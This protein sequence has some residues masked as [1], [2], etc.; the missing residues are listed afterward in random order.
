M[1]TTRSGG[2]DAGLASLPTTPPA[3]DRAMRVAIADESPLLIDGV[4]HALEDRSDIR[5]VA[6]ATSGAERMAQ[7]DGRA[8]DVVIIEPW[9]RS[10]DGLDAISAL[11]L[12][13]PKTV[14]IALST[15]QQPDHVD[16]VLSSGASGY[17]SKD[18]PPDDFASLVRRICSGVLVRPRS[19]GAG[20]PVHALTRREREVLS[21]VADGLSNQ[22]VGERLFVTEQTVKFHL[23]NIYRKLGAS[24]RT[25]A[26]R[27]AMR[28]GLIS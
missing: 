14:L 4:A 9:M 15:V 18:V 22:A 11:S 17:I 26:A 20:A 5:V 12:T 1:A 10:G 23:G 24:N 16:Q 2:L 28:A 13:H 6:R 25:E 8:A 3:T 27:R 19:A 7:I 21:L